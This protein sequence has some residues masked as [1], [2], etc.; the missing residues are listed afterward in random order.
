MYADAM[1][2]SNYR[3]VNR[4]GWDEKSST[5]YVALETKVSPSFLTGTLQMLF[6][7]LAFR[8]FVYAWPYADWMESRLK[9][10][11][12]LS[13]IEKL[14]ELDDKSVMTQ[15]QRLF[16][17]LQLLN[18]RVTKT[19]PLLKA[20]GVGETRESFGKLEVEQFIS[21]L[22]CR[23]EEEC[24]GTP[25]QGKLDPL[26]RLTERKV[27]RCSE[28]GLEMSTVKQKAVRPNRSCLWQTLATAW[29]VTW[30]STTW[31]ST[32]KSASGRQCVACTRRL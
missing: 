29:P 20:L 13:V 31:R 5:G 18:E 11:S 14:A 10:P 28:C 4:F 3:S 9:D 30:P 12:S 25:L 17:R 21:L 2:Y 24:V 7:N 8:R 15:L 6:H 23:M 26:V 22:F 1:P 16:A 19:G 32:V 27:A